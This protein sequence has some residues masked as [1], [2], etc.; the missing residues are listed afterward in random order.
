M[1]TKKVVLMGLFIALSVVGAYIKIPSPTGTVAFDSAPGYFAAA[2]IGGGE[3]ALI[4]SL[5]H[6]VSSFLVG[7]PLTLPIHFL[8]AVQ[9]AVFA[10]LFGFLL[11]KTN[12]YVAVIITTLT[13]GIIAP[14]SMAPIFGW[15][16]FVGMLLPLLAGSLV[17]I[18]LAYLVYKASKKAGVV[19]VTNSQG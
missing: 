4:I 12:G 13:N 6:L 18:L 19:F 17:N 7:F 16:F 14:L 9:M 5:G 8:I 11:R 10:Y 3:A 2:V 1:S 15:G